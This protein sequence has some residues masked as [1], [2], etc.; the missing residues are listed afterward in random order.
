MSNQNVAKIAKV[1]TDYGLRIDKRTDTD[2][3]GPIRTERSC[4][5]C[6]ALASDRTRM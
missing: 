6:E 3:Y 4:H 1:S 5:L 2:R